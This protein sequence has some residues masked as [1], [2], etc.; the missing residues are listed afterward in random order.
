MAYLALAAKEKIT[1]GHKGIM[2]KA[3]GISFKRKF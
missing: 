3:E 1:K 2:K